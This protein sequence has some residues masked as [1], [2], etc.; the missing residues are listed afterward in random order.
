[1]SS[2]RRKYNT[3]RKNRRRTS[4]VVKGSKSRKYKKLSKMIG[5]TFSDLTH[6]DPSSKTIILMG[7]E[8]TIYVLGDTSKYDVIERKQKAIIDFVIEKFTGKHIM[9]YSEAP[10]VKRDVIMKDNSRHSSR[11]IQYAST[12][13]PIQLSH[14]TACHRESD[15][16][17]D[18]RYA[19][20]ILKI[21]KDGTADCVIV[22]IGLLHVPYI[23]DLIQAS[24]KDVRIVIINTVSQDMLTRSERN[25][26]EKYPKV[27][28]LLKT[29]PPYDLPRYSA[30]IVKNES[31]V[32]VYE[33]PVCKAL[34]SP[35]AVF[36]PTNASYFI[37]DPPDCENATKVPTSESRISR[38][39]PASMSDYSSSTHWTGSVG[40]SGTN[41]REQALKQMEE[42][43]RKFSN[44]SAA[45]PFD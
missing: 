42:T 32:D 31:G 22:Q 7:E 39:S 10:N 20:E 12:K 41:Y 35:A 1:M 29:E 34:S 30:N 24:D 26:N 6:M 9:F 21:I 27:A 44:G 25:I 43:S 38:T 13:M 36:V 3:R 45:P 11:V 14:V 37:H 40:T 17:C 23:R 19:S 15:G 18:D 33:C 28:E 2:R 16:S 4:R 8:H 5:G